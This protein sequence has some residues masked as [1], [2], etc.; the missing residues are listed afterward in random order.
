M[1]T[2]RL[3]VA[4]A[5]VQFLDNQYLDVDG[6]EIKFVH[7]VAAIFGHGNV[8]GIGQALAQNAGGLTL[9]QGR[10]EQGMAHL[11][12][13]FAKQNLRQRIIACTSSSGRGRQIWLRL[14]QRQQRT[15]FLFFYYR[16][17]CLRPASRIR[18]CNKSNNLTI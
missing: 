15:V 12:M 16:A 10:N 18:Y 9:Y 3:T 2:T 7:G 11:A 5:L 4:Q 14:R 13:G 8:L 17:M 6:K 1:Q